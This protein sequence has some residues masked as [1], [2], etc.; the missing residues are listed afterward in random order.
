MYVGISACSRTTRVSRVVHPASGSQEKNPFPAQEGAPTIH[1]HQELVECLLL[2][3][4]GEARH[5]GGALLAHGVDLVN[6]HDAG[7]PGP[8]FLEEAPYTGSA[9]A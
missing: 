6:V 5:G 8:G 9:E 7:R 2:L 1:L 3:R 4:V